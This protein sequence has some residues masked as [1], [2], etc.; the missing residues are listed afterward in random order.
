MKIILTLIIVITAI[1]LCAQDGMPDSI[2]SSISKL[3]SAMIFKD[4]AVTNRISR[5]SNQSSK[6]THDSISSS[7]ANSTN[8]YERDKMP[9]DSSVINQN[10]RYLNHTGEISIRS[11][12]KSIFQFL[13]PSIIALVVGLMAYW[14]TIKSSK[15]QRNLIQ[16]QMDAN[17][18][19]VQEQIESSMKIAELDFRK[20]VLSSN[21]QAWINELRI[22]IS[23]L[24]SI[25]NVYSPASEDMI[26]GDYKRISFLMAKAE[27]MLN[28]KKDK[29]YINSITKLQESLLQF[30][31]GNKKYDDLMKDIEVV[32]KN[33]KITLKIE[34]ERVKRGE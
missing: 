33:T 30:S 29:S 15:H 11:D 7:I 17:K 13:F 5:I 32:K 27:F 34:W 3:E 1:T 25:V 18:L 24:L 12:N 19:V 31:M 23:E 14:A 22:V 28:P 2:T 6:P 26:E 9:M 20:T 16:N 8:T 4:S 21:R 10:S